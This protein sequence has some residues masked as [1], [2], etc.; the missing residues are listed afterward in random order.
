MTATRKSGRLSRAILLLCWV[1]A[2]VSILLVLPLLFHLFASEQA[3][4]DVRVPLALQAPSFGE[5]FGTDP[6]GRSQWHRSLVG[7]AISLRVVAG[8][9]AFALPISLILGTIAGSH[10]GRW[11]DH[12]ISWVIALL[13]T[14][15]FFLL[16]VSVAALVGPGTGILPWL[17]GG[18]IWAPAA[19]LV[20]TET[21][22]IRECRFVQASRAMGA[23]S[24][25]IF[26]RCLFPLVTPPATVSLF[27]LVPEIIGIDAILTLFG[28][29]PKPPTP[30]LGGLVFDGIRRWDSAP[31]LAGCPALI[32]IVLC[33][34]VHFLADRI[35]EQVNLAR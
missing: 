11:P 2:S 16:V 25:Q 23:S 18:V 10:V 15:P 35:S 27:Y 29:G 22:R 12:I 33:L 13:H 31:W 30:S 14:I 32:L 8:S 5:W 1:A 24:T 4:Y 17:V 19:R 9:L 20:R 3:A 28:L 26:F 34:G 7:A 6:L 21:I